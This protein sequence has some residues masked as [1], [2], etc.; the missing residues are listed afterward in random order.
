MTRSP[1]K[2]PTLWLIALIGVSQSAI[3]QTKPSELAGAK[4]PS[5]ISRYA[6]SVLQNAA[7]E[8]FAQLRV[9]AGPGRYESDGKLSFA[10]STDVEGKVSAFFY[11]APKAAT[12]LEMFRNY[13]AALAQGGFAVLYSCELRA[14]DQAL[15][16]EAYRSESVRPRKWAAASDPAGSVDRDIRFISAKATRSGA[17][18]YVEVFVAEPN[19]LWQAPV[20]V[21]L[22]AEPAPVE[23]G[24]VVMGSEQLKAGLADE[25]RVALYGIYFDTGRAELKAQSKAQ[26]DEMARL[27]GTDK[28][29]KV[30]I[31]GH[32]D[33][34]GSI[35]ANLT[36][37]QRRAEAVIAA[38]VSNYRIDPTRLKSSGVANYSP[39]STNHAEAGRAK[40]RRVEMVEQ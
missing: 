9:P 32:T 35:D 15:I 25:G 27:L 38:L 4:D 20:A 28:S 2:L 26:L 34:Q 24:K 22:V 39:V 29:L 40:N 19:S 18:V 6:G 33:N 31:V 1:S 8:P 36:L 16:R 5:L 23:L 10:R 7:S 14:C 11:V 17:D 30:L 21:V 13:Q 3:S 12:A 37:S